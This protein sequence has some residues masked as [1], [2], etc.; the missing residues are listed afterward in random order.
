[1]QP[2]SAGS[3]S[4]ESG[5][6]CNR[7]MS[8]LWNEKGPRSLRSR[9]PTAE[10]A[11]G[12]SAVVRRLAVAG[13]VQ[14]FALFLFRDAQADHLV[15]DEVPDQRHHTRTHDRDQPGPELEPN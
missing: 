15:D 3:T 8:R 14:A 2:P 11:S 5:P 1:M 12:R 9:G 13:D 7:I 4:H 6:A 10:E